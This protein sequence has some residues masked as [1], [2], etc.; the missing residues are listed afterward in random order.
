MA[1]PDAII[2]DDEEQ[3]RIH[4]R[5]KL[6]PLWPELDICAEAA[7]GLQALEL[8]ESHRPSIAFLDTSL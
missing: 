4:L 7:N 8:I 2:A 3:L 6:A 5:S 1:K